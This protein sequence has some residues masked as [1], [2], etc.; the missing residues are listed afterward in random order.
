MSLNRTMTQ[1][2]PDTEPRSLQV[3]PYDGIILIDKEAGKTSFSVVKELR[4]ILKIKKIGHAG[5]LDPFAT[6][7]LVILLGQGT[8]LFP[9]L[10]S[11]KKVYRATLRL[12][13]ETDTKDPTGRIIQTRSVPKFEHTYINEKIRE[14]IGEIEQVPP[15]FSAIKY[16]GKKAYE[17]A[18]KG[19][20]IEMEKRRVHI[21]DIKIISLDLPD[22]VLEISCSSGTYIRSFAADLGEK[23][24]TGA[25]LIT[26]R[27]LSSGPFTVK[28]ALDLKYSGMADSHTHFPDKIISLR[29]ALP[30]MR[31][32]EID[33]PMAHKIRKGYQPGCD[34]VLSHSDFY[35]GYIKLVKDR[36]LVAIMNVR[37][38]KGDDGG[39]SKIMRVFY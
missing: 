11:G 1:L 10:L 34:E 8:K 28:D 23:L 13:V 31:E 37:H 25:Y 6:G 24:G 16:R 27:R 32:K 5:T 20:K 15:V 7:L 12:G 18:R 30:E 22:V 29:E 17:F 4:G 2:V 3:G 14:F 35:E 33:A 19:I 21:H 36:E 26:L 38:I 39:W 9:Y